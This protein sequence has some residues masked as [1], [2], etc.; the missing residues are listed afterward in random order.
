VT[1]DE[2]KRLESIIRTQ[3]VI[4][5]FTCYRTSELLCPIFTTKVVWSR[6]L[7]L[8]K[9]L[10][11]MKRLASFSFCVQQNDSEQSK[12]TWLQHGVL[13]ALIENLPESCT[14]LEI[15]TARLRQEDYKKVHLCDTIREVLPRMKHVRLSLGQLCESMFVSDPSN[16]TKQTFN[17]HAPIQYICTAMTYEP[18][19]CVHAPLLET[20]VINLGSDEGYSIDPLSR[21]TDPITYAMTSAFEAHALPS[22]TKLSLLEME[23]P[24]NRNGG[25]EC[26]ILEDPYRQYVLWN[27]Y[28]VDVIGNQLITMPYFQA[29]GHPE[30]D[31]LRALD[32]NGTST[33]G[34]FGNWDALK[35]VSEGRACETTV[36]GPRLPCKVAKADAEDKGYVFGN[37]AVGMLE[38][39]V[40]LREM[41]EHLRGDFSG[42]E[43][44]TREVAQLDGGDLVRRSSMSPW[45]IGR[46]GAKS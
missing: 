25:S 11:T 37:K 35:S 44:F 1:G 10:P 43:C 4:G 39:N 14:G 13:K 17:D 23:I 20:L 29:Y 36:A 45:K 30:A 3:V 7:A 21:E 28:E 15:D 19:V 6:L 9:A 27:I 34:F 31:F 26:Y 32:P 16:F 8:A 46:L 18:V 42:S 40:E 38:K 41:T 24:F 33:E 2:L 5:G 22:V 12:N